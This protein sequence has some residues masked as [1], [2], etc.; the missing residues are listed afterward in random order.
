MA[1]VD[2]VIRDN[3]SP[4]AALTFAG[5]ACMVQEGL[6]TLIACLDAWL[7]ITLRALRGTIPLA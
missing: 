6:L 5:E 4:S 1:S 2:H 3:E 7:N